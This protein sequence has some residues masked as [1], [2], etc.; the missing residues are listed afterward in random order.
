MVCFCIIMATE[1]MAI[2]A[3]AQKAMQGGGGEKL[4]CNY[5]HEVN[6][7]CFEFRSTSSLHARN[8]IWSRNISRGQNFFQILS[9]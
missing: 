9:L 7:S 4:I 3:A 6:A 2:E 8:G 5:M 1:E